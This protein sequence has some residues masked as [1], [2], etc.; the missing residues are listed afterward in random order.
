MLQLYP[1]WII[2]V[3]TKYIINIIKTRNYV[4]NNFLYSPSWW[5]KFYQNNAFLV[6]VKYLRV[7][8]ISSKSIDLKFVFASIKDLF[9][10][11]NMKVGTLRNRCVPIGIYARYNSDV[12]RIP[13]KY[14]FTSYALQASTSPG[15]NTTSNCLATPTSYLTF[16]TWRRNSVSILYHHHQH[17]WMYVPSPL[18][19]F[20]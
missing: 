19:S 9:A 7:Y 18:T 20:C 12:K 8:N 1:E 10:I 4:P 2:V 17:V 11:A 5:V 16:W 14:K 13:E 6:L 3:S 15:R